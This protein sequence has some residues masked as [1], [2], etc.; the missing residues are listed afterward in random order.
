MDKGKPS[1]LALVVDVPSFLTSVSSK[2]GLA[3]TEGVT[4]AI[5]ELVGAVTVFC[6]SYALMHRENRIAVICCLG[7]HS[8]VIYPVASEQSE[9]GFIPVLHVLALHLSSRILKAVSDQLIHLASTPIADQ[10]RARGSLSQAFSMAL[11][12]LNRHKHVQS[13]VLVLQFDRDRS[14]NYNAL[15]NSIFR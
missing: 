8:E 14:Q 15:M 7:D 3:N 11:S 13:R 2:V 12:I 5:R 10:S 6:N 4:T 9:A 1:F